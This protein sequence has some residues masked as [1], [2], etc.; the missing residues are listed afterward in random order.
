MHIRNLMD[1]QVRY[2]RVN[3]RKTKEFF[4]GTGEYKSGSA[5]NHGSVEFEREVGPQSTDKCV[6]LLTGSEVFNTLRDICHNYTRQSV[7]VF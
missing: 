7:S 1:K 5:Q 6:R 2:F 4:H 3:V